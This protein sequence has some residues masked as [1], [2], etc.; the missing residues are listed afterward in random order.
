[1][2]RKE[3]KDL[4]LLDDFL[5]QELLAREEGEEFCRI[6][7]RTILGKE[8]HNIKIIPQKVISGRSPGKHGIKIDA[9]IEADT[10]SQNTDTAEVELKAEIYDIEP[11]KYQAK[12]E[13]HRTRYYHSLIDSKILKSGISYQNLK[14]VIII[15]ILPYDPF[16]KN[17]MVYTFQK[18]CI[19]D[20]TI[21]YNEGITT[22]Y[23]YTKGT[24]GNPSQE[25]RDML[26]YI[27]SS[28]ES[29]ITND[30]LAHINQMV[31]S[32]RHDE[33]VGVSYMKSW[34]Y[35]QM[36]LEEGIEKGRTKGLSEGKIKT[37]IVQIC[38]KILKNHSVE[39]IAE[40]LEEPIETVQII[41]DIA[42][43]HAPDY[44]VDTIYQSYNA[45]NQ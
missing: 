27:E 32:V 30:D 25:L 11:N 20:S 29:N 42:K 43:K 16:G 9:Y 39:E 19:E 36:W 37:L 28:I 13:A 1:M 23:L 33:E 41:Y 24:E 31:E 8:L 3:L 10:L 34:E 44:D 26:Q 4:N 6:L 7:L 2:E 22:I 38:K 40:M 14:N 5:F 17:R 45:L 18:Q 15:M 35:E 21:P 12:E